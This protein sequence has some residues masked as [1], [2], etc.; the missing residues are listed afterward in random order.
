VFNES[1]KGK[2][3]LRNDLAEAVR[4][5]MLLRAW[6]ASLRGPPSSAIDAGGELLSSEVFR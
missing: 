6:S 3:N 4:D 5:F 2:H 1:R